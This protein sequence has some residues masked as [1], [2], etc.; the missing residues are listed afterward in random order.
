MRPQPRRVLDHLKAGLP[1]TQQEA[2]ALYGI[3]RLASRVS[4]LRQGGQP[5]ETRFVK[6]KNRFGE[7]VHYAEYSL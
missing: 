3:G 5:V 2:L 1:I 4:E 7:P 6:G